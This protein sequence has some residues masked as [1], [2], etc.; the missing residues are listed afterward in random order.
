MKIF[1]YGLLLLFIGLKLSANIQWSWF[2]VLT[3][4][5]VRLLWWFAAIFLQAAINMRERELREEGYG[6][7]YISGH[8]PKWQQRFEEMKKAQEAHK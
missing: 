3:P 2:L 7:H 1:L 4:L 8:K 5:W 6:D